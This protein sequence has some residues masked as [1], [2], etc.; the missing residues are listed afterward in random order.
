MNNN[1]LYHHGVK[2][3]KWGKRKNHYGVGT[4]GIAGE[5]YKLRGVT[6]GPTN[7]E[8]HKLR[9]VATGPINGEKPKMRG[10]TS[11][12]D[13]KQFRRDVKDY[14]KR[15]IL[16]DY[17]IT[18]FRNSNGQKVGREYAEKVMR[19]GNRE[20]AISTIIGS[21]AAIAG[22]AVASRLLNNP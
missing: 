14:K 22:V 15:G 12:Y 9:G 10:V 18:Q 5:K 4:S 16:G 20:K 21:T 7:G 8:K 2:G 1:E 19:Q 11:G 6:T 13:R 17:E 3:M